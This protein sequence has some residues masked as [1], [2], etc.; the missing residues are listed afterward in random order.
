MS[1]E[2]VD[3]STAGS[4]TDTGSA[5]ADWSKI[6]EESL[7]RQFLV[8]GSK[9]YRKYFYPVLGVL[10]LAI[11][12]SM[13]VVGAYLHEFL[14]ILFMYVGLACLWNFLSGYSGYVLFGVTI[15]FGV[16]AY[17]TAGVMNAFAV[18][19]PVG[20]LAAAL[21]SL[22]ISAV[23]GYILLRISGIYFAIGTL[24]IVEGT[25][26]A[27]FVEDGVTGH[28]GG[29]SGITV[30]PVSSEIT[31]LGFGLLAL[32]TIALTYE[33]ATSKFGLRMMAIREDEEA[34]VSLGVNPLR[35][36]LTAFVLISI[37]MGIIGGMYVL[38]LGFMYP[39]TPF[40]HQIILTVILAAILGG[41]GTVWG[42]VLGII[43][44]VPLEEVLWLNYP[45]IFLVLYGLCLMAVILFI[46]DGIINRLKTMG[47]LP[48]SRSV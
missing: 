19:W 7:W 17:A 10:A 38:T 27:I 40:N 13:F 23:I 39:E 31:F 47:I 3:S 16:G 26:E 42:P 45:D 28:L 41:R 44:L 4:R 30:S 5:D 43:I 29:A 22:G 15:F 2:H 6:T 12:T 14:Y 24:L 36:K 8:T 35:Y 32:F 18:S 9:E 1:K 25:R 34:L 48:N 33:L 11:V 20:L 46:P 37:V 21:I